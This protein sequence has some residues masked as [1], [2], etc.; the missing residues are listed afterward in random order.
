MQPFLDPTLYTVPDFSLKPYFSPAS[1]WY[2]FSVILVRTLLFTHPY[3]GVHPIFKSLAQR[4]E[5]RVSILSTAV[6]YPPKARPHAVLS[7]ALRDFIGRVFEQ[8]ERPILTSQ[9]LAD[10]AI[11]LQNPQIGT[12]TSYRPTL[13]IPHG[14]NRHKIL[15]QTEGHIL[16]VWPQAHSGRYYALTHE[17]GVFKLVYAGIGGVISERPLFN[18]TPDYRF[19][20]FGHYLIINPPQRQQLLILD[21]EQDPPQRIAMLESDIF[22]DGAEETAVFATTPHHYYRLLN[23]YLMRGAITGQAA[24]DE[25]SGTAYQ[26]QTQLWG[27][28]H[29]DT[30]IALHRSFGEYTLFAK[31]HT[32]K[33]I[34]QAIQL[35]SKASLKQTDCAFSPDSGSLLLQVVHH[36]QEQS[37][38]LPLGSTTPMQLPF[39]AERHV[40]LPSGFYFP[41]DMGLI[42]WK[43]GTHTI[44]PNTADWITADDILHPH[45][46]GILTQKSQKLT[47]IQI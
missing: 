36:G 20:L 12:T 42:K 32:G 38:L 45:P 16:A 44:L 13:T 29:N 40:H 4:A 31:L 34:E 19:G 9:L 43:N 3:G 26:H 14:P 35:P 15:W 30:V 11:Y 25:I 23:G 41:T 2:A 24:V 18:G 37:Y 27:S 21:I 47:L 33:T 17:A 46:N 6:K 5:N 10:Y 8:G 1:D 39:T 22:R 7:P 28:S